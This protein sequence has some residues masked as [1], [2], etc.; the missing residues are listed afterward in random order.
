[1]NNRFEMAIGETIRAYRKK[2]DITQEQLAEY[3]S[4]SFQSVSKWERGDAYPDITMLPRIALFFGITTDELL[5][6]DRLK[7]DEEIEGYIQR[8]N[9]ALA[10][11]NTK[12]AVAIMREA[13]AKYPGNFRLMEILAGVIYFEADVCDEENYRDS[14][15][16]VISIGEKIRAE[17]RDDKIRRDVLYVMCSAYKNLGESEKAIR[18]AQENL[19]SFYVT[20]DVVLDDLLEGD[21][22]TKNRQGNLMTFMGYLCGEMYHL[23][24]DFTCPDKLQVYE[25]R[26]K[27]FNMIFPDGDFGYYNA[28]MSWNYMDVAAV[29]LEQGDGAN[30]VENIGRAAER[31]ID[32][33]TLAIPTPHTSP[34]VI[35]SPNKPCQPT[36][37]VI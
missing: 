34:L 1:M 9:Q 24:Q 6:V 20:L 19:G 29:Y 13:N 21:A 28:Q 10:V 4:I 26:I 36:Q 3:L 8:K 7:S 27:I 31:V 32:M 16:E 12:E 18:L 37:A 11:G 33:D 5:C 2:R 17:C 30:A 23:A 15:R 22:L 14:W 25:N 35:N